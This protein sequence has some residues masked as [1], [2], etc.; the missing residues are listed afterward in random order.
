MRVEK[1]PY[2]AITFAEYIDRAMTTAVKYRVL[3]IAGVAREFDTHVLKLADIVR[4]WKAEKE[5]AK[6][7]EQRYLDKYAGPA[8]SREN[9][10]LPVFA[11]VKS[12]PKLAK[13]RRTRSSRNRALSRKEKRALKV[14]QVSRNSRQDID[15]AE[16]ED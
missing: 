14:E 16:E 12:L 7:R 3:T 13:T 5:R 11:Q 10:H 8:I 15:F 1:N 6:R 9:A 4:E 2:N